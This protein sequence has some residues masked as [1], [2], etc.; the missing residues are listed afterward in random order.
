MTTQS[1]S[2]PSAPSFLREAQL[3]WQHRTTTE[4]RSSQ[5]LTRFLSESL[6]A[7]DPAEVHA[8]I[9]DLIA[10]ELEHVRLCES[11]CRDLG[12]TPTRPSK[13]E[14]NDPV[15]FTQ[16][17]ARERALHTAITMMLINETVSVG[18]IQDLEARCQ[19]PSI[20]RVLTATLGDESAHEQFGYD[21]VK[22]GLAHYGPIALNDF[23]HLV[24]LALAPHEG[25]ARR[26]LQ[27]VPE[28][29]CTLEAWPDTQRISLGLFSPERQA[30]VYQRTYR[31]VLAPKLLALGLIAATS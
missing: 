29:K 17:P 8:V 12:V 5:I 16:A 4:Y 9:L 27:N 13:L 24:A 15:Q 14:L 31:E 23:R 28:E 11:V 22:R 7:S 25:G 26:A 18:F 2:S 3:T 1:S 6:A 30:L 19:T 21:Y 20:K 10:D